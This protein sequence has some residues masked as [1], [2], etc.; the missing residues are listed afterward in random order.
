MATEEN[1]EY[2]TT[3]YTTTTTVT[4]AM[5]TEEKVE[6]GSDR[7]LSHEDGLVRDDTIIASS[8]EINEKSDITTAQEYDENGNKRNFTISQTEKRLVRKLDFIYVM[9]FV[10][11]L[12]FLQFFDKSTLNYAV[13]MG[14]QQ[15]THLTGSQFSWLT[16]IF[17]LGYLIFQ[18]PGTFLI[19]KLPLNKYVGTLIVLWGLVLLL[20]FLARNFSQLAALRFLLGFFEAGIYPACV[21]L[22]STLYRRNE[23]SGRIGIV[24]ICNGLA[25]IIGGFISYGVAY[26]HDNGLE[27]W[28]WIMI[29]LGAIT[30]A[31]GVACFFFMVDSPK[32]KVLRLSA[33][34]ERI[35]E[36]RTEDNAV[37][38]TRNF[39][40]S[41][42][43]ESLKEPRYY[44]LLICSLLITLQNSALGSFNTT[45][46]A[47]FGFS[48]LQSIL[49]TIPSGA[50]TCIFILIGVYFNR[51]YG[52]TLYLASLFLIVAIIGLILLLVIP[53]FKVKLLGLILVW[54]YCASFVMLLTVVANNVAG[55]TKKV[56]Y[57]S[58]IMIFYTLGNFIGP[59]M[60][61]D[62]QKPLYI[63]GMI[64]FIVAD[65][66]CIL[67]YMYLRWTMIRENRRRLALPAKM[68]V[69]DDMTDIENKNYIYRP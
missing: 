15:S 69:V 67:L 16:S 64:G 34:E 59:F 13:P 21:M 27:P 10:A 3:A 8:I 61:V 52:H 60:M 51:R 9:P 58:S 4:T 54:S 36:E 29:I 48:K 55:Y 44:C 5:T 7:M 28:Q 31:F 24:Y 26:M 33:E 43:Y 30:M 6:T 20:T 57:S 18:I 19:Q 66:I 42:I 40:I 23:Q 11:I 1:K 49:L 22:I 2:Y 65:F 63:G 14:I 17:Y 46:T 39:K 35:V 37:V 47:G 45:I 25:M 56:F 62:S 12:N 38:R 68:E 50:S 32:S 53:A 41:H